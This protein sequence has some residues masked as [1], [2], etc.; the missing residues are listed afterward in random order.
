[1]RRSDLPAKASLMSQP[2][3]IPQRIIP[4]L[5]NQ[6]RTQRIGDNVSSNCLQ[7]PLLYEWRDRDNH[8]AKLDL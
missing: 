8:A 6:T 7:H 5:L 3:R 1:M 2:D 4:Y